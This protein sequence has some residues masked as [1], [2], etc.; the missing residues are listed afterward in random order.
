M[1]MKWKYTGSNVNVDGGSFG[2][3]DLKYLKALNKADKKLSKTHHVIPQLSFDIWEKNNIYNT[4][5]IKIKNL[6]DVNDYIKY[7]F[8]DDKIIGVI[9]STGTGDGSFRCLC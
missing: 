6:N 1:N 8:D 2:F 4:H 7:G 3:W 5:I 9:S